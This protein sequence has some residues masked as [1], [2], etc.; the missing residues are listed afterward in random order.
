MKLIAMNLEF[1]KFFKKLS[2]H[3]NQ[4][5][6]LTLNTIGLLPTETLI[7]ILYKSIFHSIRN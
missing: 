2:R 4:N 6:L 7:K 1:K 3:G 5:F